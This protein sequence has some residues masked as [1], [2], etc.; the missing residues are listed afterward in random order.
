MSFLTYDGTFGATD[1]VLAFI[2]QFDAAFGD[3]GFTESSKLRHVAMHFQKSARQWWASLRGNGEAPK[4]WKTLRVSIMKQF[5]PSNTK[6]K[7]LTEWRGLKLLS[8]ESIN[9]YVDKFWDLHLK[10]TVFQ[11][12]DFAE[13]RQQFCAGLP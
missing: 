9:K 6:D 12:I 10:A 7:V 8:H 13:Q 11:K 5:L 2:Q 4:T 3:E 1:K